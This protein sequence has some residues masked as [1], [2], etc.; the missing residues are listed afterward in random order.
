MRSC[1]LVLYLQDAI[2]KSCMHPSQIRLPWTTKVLWKA[3]A[4][5]SFATVSCLRAVSNDKDEAIAQIE[6]SKLT[7]GQSGMCLKW[8]AEE[9]A[10]LLRLALSVFDSS[11]TRSKLIITEQRHVFRLDSHINNIVQ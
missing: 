4:G 7:P 3:S 10:D 5:C 1:E 11:V 9:V 6:S 8:C 2:S